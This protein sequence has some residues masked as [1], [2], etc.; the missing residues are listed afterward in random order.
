M[1]KRPDTMGSWSGPLDCE[2]Q[3]V[4]HRQCLEQAGEGFGGGGQGGEGIGGG[5]QLSLDWTGPFKDQFY[6]LMEMDC[7][8]SP[9]Y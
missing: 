3:E 4:I 2:N 9:R 6:P 8:V 1:S 7:Y 5:C